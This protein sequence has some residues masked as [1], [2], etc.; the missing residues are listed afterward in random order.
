L[1][2]ISAASMLALN[3]VIQSNSLEISERPRWDLNPRITDLQSVPLGHLGTRPRPYPC[4]ERLWRQRNEHFN[5]QIFWN[6]FRSGDFFASPDAPRSSANRTAR[7]RGATSRLATSRLATSRVTT[8]RV[9]NRCAATRRVTT[10]RLA[11]RCAAISRL[12]T[13]CAAIKHIKNY[14]ASTIV[15]RR[16]VPNTSPWIIRAK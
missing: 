13:C 15:A 16:R 6:H 8:N 1:R 10:S 11:T 4:T 3:A 7:H 5:L 12:A 14:G 9:A 2:G